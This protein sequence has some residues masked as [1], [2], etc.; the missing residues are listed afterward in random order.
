MCFPKA[1]PTQLELNMDTITGIVPIEPQLSSKATDQSIQK[2]F[3]I[4][5]TYTSY[6]KIILSTI[7]QEQHVCSQILIC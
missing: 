4:I 5:K 3:Q 2:I 6:I 7:E 1:S